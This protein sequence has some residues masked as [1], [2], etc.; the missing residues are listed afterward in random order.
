MCWRWTY[1]CVTIARKMHN[2]KFV[3]TQQAKTVY[4]FKDNKEKN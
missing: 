4:N 3:K 1:L 2:I